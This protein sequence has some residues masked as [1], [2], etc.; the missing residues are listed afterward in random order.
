MA[1]IG[2]NLSEENNLGRNAIS[3]AAQANQVSTITWLRLQEV[4]YLKKDKKLSTPLHWAVFYG[5]ENTVTLLLNWILKD[6]NPESI[7]EKDDEGMT[8]L[9]L[10]VLSGNG[11]I[12]KRLI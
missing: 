7:N 8:P 6:N 2:V 9:H 3:F 4:D 10:A 12:I 1:A 5:C 11:K